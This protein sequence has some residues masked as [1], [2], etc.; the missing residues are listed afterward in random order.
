MKAK[1]KFRFIDESL[2]HDRQMMIKE[3]RKHFTL[4]GMEEIEKLDNSKIQTLFSIF[5]G[6]M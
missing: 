6:R 5:G 2:N 4:A 1:P 3:M